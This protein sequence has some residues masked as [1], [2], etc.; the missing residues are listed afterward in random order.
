MIY[1][2]NVLDNYPK[3]LKNINLP[4][5]HQITFNNDPALKIKRS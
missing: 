4:Q 2:L 3:Q 5:I 1:P